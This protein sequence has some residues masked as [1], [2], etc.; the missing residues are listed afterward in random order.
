MKKRDIKKFQGIVFNIID[1]EPEF[2]DQIPDDA[3]AILKEFIRQENKK[4]VNQM[5]ELSNQIVKDA[6]KEAIKEKFEKGIND[7]K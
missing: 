2:N 5:F 1:T 6:I 4:A 7:N 3:W